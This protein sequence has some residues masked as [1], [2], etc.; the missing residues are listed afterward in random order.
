MLHVWASDPDGF[1]AGWARSL[2][3][4]RPIGWSLSVVENGHVEYHY[5]GT[6]RQFRIAFDLWH[7]LLTAP[8]WH[9]EHEHDPVRQA[10]KKVIDRYHHRWWIP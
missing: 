3:E 9:K 6:A 8:C 4:T 1:Q 5:P 2:D 7:D 10:V